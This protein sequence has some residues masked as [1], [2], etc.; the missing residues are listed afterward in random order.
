MSKDQK[1]GLDEVKEHLISLYEEV[2][3]TDHLGNIIF[4]THPSQTNHSL[5]HPSVLGRVQECGEK[6]S[7]V[8][9]GTN[10]QDIL[11]NGNPI[12]NQYG[13]I[14][15]ILLT[16][17][18]LSHDEQSVSQSED[19][20]VVYSDN[21]KEVLR[22]AKNVASTSVT[23][24]LIG[25]SGV[26]KE[27]VS[28]FIH[29]N[30][31]RSKQPFIK[32]N[33]GAIPEKLLESELFGYTKGAFTGADPKGK[34]GYFTQAD[35]GIIFLDEISEMPLSLQVKLLRVL[36]EREVVPVGATR[37]VK[38]DVQIIAATNKNLEEL[39]ER[40]EFRED[41]F[42][43]LN[44]VPITI[45]PLRERPEEI[46]FLAQLF[47]KKYNEMYRRDVHLTNAAID[48]LISY[49]WPGNVRELENVM[50]RVVVTSEQKEVTP[51]W[52]H[53]ISP[54]KT[55]SG[56]NRKPIIPTIIPL[57]EAL[58]HV[59]EQLIL[60]AMKQH[61]SLKNAAEVLQ[62]SQPTMSRKYKKIKEK[63][64][65]KTAL[66]QSQPYNIIEDELNN[67]LIS[68]AKITAAS[69]RIEDIKQ[70]SQ[71]LSKQNPAYPKLQNQLTHIRKIEG[72]ISWNYIFTVTPDKCVYNLVA[73]RRLKLS[74]GEE[75]TGPPEIIDCMILA[76]RGKVGVTPIYEDAFGKMKSSVTPIKDE[77][78][79][80]IAILG[81]DFS[82]AYVNAQL[83]KLK[84]L[85]TT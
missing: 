42:Y 29:E 55:A 12:K 27:M 66:S 7:L 35:K 31:V 77:T 85:F 37:P 38:I 59:E 56:K 57:D 79:Q 67:Q 80:V 53:K 11:T 45:P 62:V 81:S 65:N 32:V 28:T 60:M 58:D 47:I 22:Q 33:C 73:D 4:S 76:M 68:I 9:Q 21:M 82:E 20:F 13:Q 8:H 41:L 5:C 34:S 84:K 14:D 15:K 30:G 64:D 44:V 78:G 26:G 69:V 1:F 46:S 24:L 6:I 18:Y 43:R 70:L 48:L 83:N 63:M 19:S 54:M 49:P 71:N 51:E 3:L 36:Q 72:Q 61:T 52:I 50:Q 2:I 16:A 39:V 75:Y 17:S 40:G 10:G 74:P 25:E 23:V